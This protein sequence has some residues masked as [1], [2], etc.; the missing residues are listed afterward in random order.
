MPIF[1]LHVLDEKYCDRLKWAQKT[2]S[3]K[4]ENFKVATFKAYS[5]TFHHIVT[6]SIFFKFSKYM[7]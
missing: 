2:K 3:M 4:N 7:Y 6:N 1:Y 5:K